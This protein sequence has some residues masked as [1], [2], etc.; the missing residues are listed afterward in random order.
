MGFCSIALLLHTAMLRADFNSQHP[1]DSSDSLSCQ[2][3]PIQKLPPLCMPASGSFQ[4]LPRHIH[5]EI[6]SGLHAPPDHCGEASAC[7]PAVQVRALVHTGVVKYLEFK[8]VDGSYVLNRNKV[9]RVPA[10]D[11]EA[12]KSPLLG[13]FEKRRAR[14]FFLCVLPSPA[15]LLL[16]SPAASLLRARAAQMQNCHCMEQVHGS[17]QLD[18]GAATDV[19]TSACC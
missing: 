18:I 9:E 13:L 15:C 3:V 11:F 16:A 1:F 5:T 8:A 2:A 19:H 10:T 17:C 6:L 7:L 14:N 12:L 4:T